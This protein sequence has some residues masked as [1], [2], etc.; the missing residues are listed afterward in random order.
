VPEV[1]PL[2][3]RICDRALA[4][5]LEDR[6]DTAWDFRCE[7]QDYMQHAGVRVEPAEIGQLMHDVFD[8]ER[9][10]IHV[11]I[12]QAMRN[13]DLSASLADDLSAVQ[14]DKAPTTVADLSS[15]V[16]ISLERDDQKIQQGYA[17]SK[18]RLVE[19]TGAK[20]RGVM[21]KLTQSRWLRAIAFT[22]V[23]V[24]AIA[25]GWALLRD[26]STE[27]IT[28]QPLETQTT[29]NAATVPPP[30]VATPRKPVEAL[31][32]ATINPPS[33]STYQPAPAPQVF[34]RPSRASRASRQQ[35]SVAAK[36]DATPGRSRNRAAATAPDLPTNP[37]DS[38][39]SPATT[40]APSQRRP[41][42][43]SDLTFIRREPVRIDRESPYR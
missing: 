30:A 37:P 7:L 26:R 21:P 41:E 27:K 33:T 28:V 19:S 5:H 14:L 15:L 38:T 34:D 13:T 32:P 43:G 31:D 3:A 16:E 20:K 22:G 10:T 35:L 24:V 1:D 6:F 25:G 8:A 18:V 42:E 23:C 29:R 11:R 36:T 4:V 39:P 40:A 9:R 12:E 2:L 17:H